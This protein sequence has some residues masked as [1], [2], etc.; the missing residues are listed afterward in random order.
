LCYP[1]LEVFIRDSYGPFC[2]GICVFYDYRRIAFHFEEV[3]PVFFMGNPDLK[4]SIER[5]SS[6]NLKGEHRLSS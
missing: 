3:Q 2:G 6:Y 1:D 4:T 5:R